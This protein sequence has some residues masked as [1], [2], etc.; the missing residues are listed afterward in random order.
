MHSFQGTEHADGADPYGSL[1][2]DGTWLYGTTSAG[3]HH[4]KGTVF[5]IAP[6]P[7]GAVAMPQIVYH[8]GDNASDG[9]KPIDNV[10]E[11]DGMLY[12]MTVYGGADVASPDYPGKTGRGAIFAVPVPP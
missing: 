8:F 4:D 1:M 5:R 3:G 7:F 10:I 6:V 9:S 2:F 11:L 12:G